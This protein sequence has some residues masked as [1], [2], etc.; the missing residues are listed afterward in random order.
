MNGR[1]KEYLLLYNF[2]VNTSKDM[3]SLQT[4]TTSMCDSAKQ[5][6][7]RGEFD[8]AAAILYETVCHQ[9]A[10]LQQLQRAHIRAQLMAEHTRLRGDY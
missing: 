2:M 1:K 7:Q 5:H 10:R 8:T 3:N 6:Y 4:W 9:E